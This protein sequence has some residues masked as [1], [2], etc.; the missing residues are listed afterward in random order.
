MGWFCSVF[1]VLFV[2]SAVGGRSLGRSWGDPASHNAHIKRL[3][4]DI[5]EST[6]FQA[7]NS[8]AQKDRAVKLIARAK[9]ALS[10]SS[11][12]QQVRPGMPRP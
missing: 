1:F 2:G 5:F 12:A 7:L 8:S 4:F 10:E 11:S 9:G 6:D 3:I